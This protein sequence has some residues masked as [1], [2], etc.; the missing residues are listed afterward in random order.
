VPVNAQEA[1][2]A[3]S[4][5]RFACNFAPSDVRPNPI[6]AVQANVSTSLFGPRQQLKQSI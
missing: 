5:P 6:V 1:A 3:E 2:I 4:G